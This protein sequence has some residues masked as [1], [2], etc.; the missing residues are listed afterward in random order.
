M[1]TPSWLAPGH[2][3][4]DCLTDLR[5]SG[6]KLSIWFLPDDQGFALRIAVAMAAMRDRIDTFDYAIFDAALLGESGFEVEESAGG[7][8]DAEVNTHH[9]DIIKLSAARL[10]ELAIAM[11]RVG[12][13][14]ERITKREMTELLGSAVKESKLDRGR[15]TRKI[16]DDLRAAEAID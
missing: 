13:H 1:D 6:N 15:V 8:P 3:A 11:V 14:F 2:I 7:T 4:A 12:P 5:T 10:L 9:R 16:L